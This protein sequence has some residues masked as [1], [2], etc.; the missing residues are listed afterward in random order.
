MFHLPPTIAQIFEGEIEDRSIELADDVKPGE[1]PANGAG[2]LSQQQLEAIVGK[3]IEGLAPELNKRFS[4]FQSAT[5]KKMNE[6]REDLESPTSDDASEP[7]SGNTTTASRAQRRQAAETRERET[8]LAKRE[9]ALEFG[10][11][12]EDVE[13]DTPDQMR[14]HLLTKAISALVQAKIVVP[15]VKK[16]DEAGEKPRPFGSFTPL[17]SGGNPVTAPSSLTPE[18]MIQAGLAKRFKEMSP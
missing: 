4:G 2:Q 5:D 12:V 14:I 17:A 16:S 3:V 9:I 8:N 15:E 1:T 6:L 18:G 7:K 10:V 13:G 11:K